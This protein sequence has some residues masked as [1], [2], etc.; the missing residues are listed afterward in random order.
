MQG[1]LSALQ[2]AW[3]AAAATVKRET[4]ATA[5]ELAREFCRSLQAVPDAP[6]WTLRADTIEGAYPLFCKSL[7]IV[8]P[9]PYRDFAHK[10]KAV[11]PYRRVDKRRGGGNTYTEY[12]IPRLQTAANVVELP[13][14]A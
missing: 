8:E 6:G 2:K 7:G 12:I 1:A 11:M 13:K 10:L 3:E 5:D 9:P 4:R 14:R